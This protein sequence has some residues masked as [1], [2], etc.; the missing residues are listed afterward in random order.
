MTWPTT[1]LDTYTESTPWT[2]DN[3]NRWWC[4]T[5]DG[6]DVV[7]WVPAAPA[8][9]GGASTYADLTDAATV[10]LPAVNTPLSTALGLKLDA[11][12]AS[13]TNA[14]TPT[15][16]THP[17]AELTGVTPA[18]IGAPSGSGT[19][20]GTNTG[21]ETAAR[22]ATA[23]NAG[24]E[25]TTAADTDRLAVTNPAG[26]W[27]TLL[28][29]WTWIK[30]KVESVALTFTSHLSATAQG[31]GTGDNS[32]M[33]RTLSDARY[34]SLATALVVASN[35]DI[36]TATLAD[37]AGASTVLEASSVYEFS[38]FLHVV[39]TGG[40]PTNRVQFRLAYTG[41]LQTVQGS[42]FYNQTNGTTFPL[43]AGA[44]LTT[45]FADATNVDRAFPVYGFLRTNAAGTLTLQ[46]YRITGGTLNPY[47]AAGSRINF[48]KIA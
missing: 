20:S 21:D 10:D 45:S 38:G 25:D 18:A 44:L 6:T 8:S 48:R 35:I 39:T 17:F 9:T 37:L 13:V 7:Q 22:I 46:A 43:T 16:H 3:G 15:A 14:R 26:G 34:G 12:D 32:L 27:M 19:S 23:M 11:D 24:T 28:T 40:T 29:L 30:G 1:D 41:T 36:T 2:D 4:R 47:L 42:L 5:F 33:T 31:T